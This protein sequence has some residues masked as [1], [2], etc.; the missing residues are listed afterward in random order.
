[1]TLLTLMIKGNI[2]I[3]QLI[4]KERKLEIVPDEINIGGMIINILYYIYFSY[5][6]SYFWGG[7][8]NIPLIYTHIGSGYL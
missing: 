1:M 8:I 6:L 5:H 3:M 4:M 2:E 7:K